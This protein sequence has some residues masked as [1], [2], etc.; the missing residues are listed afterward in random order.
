MTSGSND[1]F[2][3]RGVMIDFFKDDGNSDAR[4]KLTILVIIGNRTQR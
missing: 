1:G 2:F 3:N 4:L